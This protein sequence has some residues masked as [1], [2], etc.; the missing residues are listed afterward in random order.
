MKNLIVKMSAAL[1]SP[2]GFFGEANIELV[3]ETIVEAS[4]D[5]LASNEGD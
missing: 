2:K 4:D 5:F 3:Q 1:L